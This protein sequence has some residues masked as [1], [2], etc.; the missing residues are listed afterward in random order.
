MKR[1]LKAV[2]NSIFIVLAFPLALLTGFGRQVTMFQF[3]GQ[4]CSLF[5]GLP[6][7]YLRVAYYH[8]TL[9][10]CSLESRISIGSFFADPNVNVAKSVYIGAYCVMG[11]CRIGERTL[12]ATAAQILSG[13][14]QHPRQADGTLQAAMHQEGGVTIGA[15]C[16][17]GAAAIVMDHVGQGS[18]VAA[19]AIV[20][21][22][23]PP[24]TV[25]AGNP[26]RILK[27]STEAGATQA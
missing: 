19:G 24:G 25:V 18:T 21:K 23:V 13:K 11:A 26:A 9:A 6:G 4:F 17:I 7:D 3:F 12:I 1:A 27:P 2:L 22:P 16:W 20:T 14:N 8:L 10:Q 15:D 5:P